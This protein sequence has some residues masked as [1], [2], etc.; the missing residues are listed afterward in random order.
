M[1]NTEF[2]LKQQKQYAF[3]VMAHHMMR[4]FRRASNGIMCSYRT[5]GGLSCPVG[6][7]MN[8]ELACLCR[9]KTVERLMDTLVEYPFSSGYRAL[10]AL[11]SH[12][13]KMHDNPQPPGRWVGELHLCAKRFDLD[14]RSLERSVR[15]FGRAA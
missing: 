14:T 5:R 7:F 13:Q 9:N 6:I 4:Q 11:F 12:M 2:S 1:S 3:D 10:H 8:D 15:K